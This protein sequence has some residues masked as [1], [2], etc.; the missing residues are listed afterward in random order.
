MSIAKKF[1]E[2]TGNTYPVKDALKAM[3]ARW[4]PD[5]KCWMISAAKAD[6]AN[7]L[8]SGAGPKAPYRG[9]PYR[10]ARSSSSGAG[11]RTGCYCGSRENYSQASDCSSCKFDQDDN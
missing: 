3:G 8:V 11:P 6:A 2:I 7:A 10:G 4:A 9:A 1:I 5:K